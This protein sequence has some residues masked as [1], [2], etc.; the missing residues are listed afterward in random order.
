MLGSA[1]FGQ[2]LQLLPL[3]AVCVAGSSEV[4]V[5]SHVGDKELPRCTSITSGCEAGPGRLPAVCYN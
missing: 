3:C 5:S 4:K 1:S 2:P